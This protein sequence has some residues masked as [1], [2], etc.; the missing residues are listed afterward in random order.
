MKGRSLNKRCMFQSLLSHISNFLTISYICDVFITDKGKLNM[1][2]L[3]QH[4]IHTTF[5][6]HRSD[7]KADREETHTH[8][9]GTAISE[10]Y[11]FVLQ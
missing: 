11:L 9:V 6:L 5:S 2:G 7:D 3:Q 1:R 4:N 10:A 8:T